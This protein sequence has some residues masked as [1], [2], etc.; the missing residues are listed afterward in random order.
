MSSITTAL[1]RGP[2]PTRRGSFR[3]SRQWDSFASAPL[4]FAKTLLEVV[5]PRSELAVAAP[6]EAKSFRK[7]HMSSSVQL[8][9]VARRE[10][11]R[12]PASCLASFF[13]DVR[14]S[15]PGLTVGSEVAG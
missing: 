2:G 5:W 12:I 9:W 14:E 4:R 8:R 1:S 10:T 11:R 7:L 15:F 3:N 6:S 13:P